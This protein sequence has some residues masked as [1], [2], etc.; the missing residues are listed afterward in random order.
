MHQVGWDWS[1]KLKLV[2]LS[3]SAAVA[4][5]N[6]SER[7]EDAT[8]GVVRWRRSDPVLNA[9]VCWPRVGVVKGVLDPCRAAAVLDP[10]STG[11]G[12]MGATKDASPPAAGGWQERAAGR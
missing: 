1:C 12:S 4:E 7:L 3:I 9:G 6:G 11:V 10:A 8:W 5:L 2:I